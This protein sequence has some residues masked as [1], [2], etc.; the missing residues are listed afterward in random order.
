MKILLR[1]HEEG[2]YVWKTAKYNYGKFHV[3]GEQVSE[4]N[5]VAIEN[6]NRKNYIQCS[7]CGHVFRR[8]DYR[9]NAHKRNAVKP[10]TC[11]NCP[12]MVSE[13]AVD[14]KVKYEMDAYGNFVRKLE[15]DVNLVCSK[16]GRWSY[17]SITSDSAILGC[18]K[19][20]CE[21][22][23]EIEI[24]DFFTRNHGVF[25]DIITIDVLFDNGYDA[26]ISDRYSMCYSDIE[27]EDDYTLGVCINKLGIVDK[28]YVYY[29][30]DRY[31]I[32]YSKKYDELFY[33]ASGR[34]YGIFDPAHMNT[35]VRNEIK[36]KIAKLY[37]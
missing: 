5:I 9:F 32:Y 26:N 24:F 7:C 36:A 15:Q 33:E 13:N 34:E 10:E 30:G 2:Q 8:G 1:E 27:F 12:Y 35:E 14:L 3:D 37:N 19:R 23:E 22:A 31:F 18:R 11:F 25:D 21:C 16:S 20:Q 6:D 17:A 28:F 29:R 4:V